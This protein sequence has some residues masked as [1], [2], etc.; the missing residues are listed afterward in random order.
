M[1][2]WIMFWVP[3][4][5][6]EDKFKTYRRLMF[7]LFPSSILN[8]SYELCLVFLGVCCVQNIDH[9]RRQQHP[10][11]EGRSGSQCLHKGGNHPSVYRC[12]DIRRYRR[13]RENNHW[14]PPSSFDRDG[15]SNHSLPLSRKRRPDE[16]PHFF[17]CP[18]LVLVALF[19]FSPL[20][21]HLHI[22]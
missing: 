18:F 7:I 3:V 12:V 6:I 19:R 1:Q 2:D 5:V 21:L 14:S 9:G 15:T 8:T 17:C 11:F 4:R 16:E 22:I 20:S 13:S 10:C